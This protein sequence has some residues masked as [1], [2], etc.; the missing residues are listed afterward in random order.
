M[1]ELLELVNIRLVI[2]L[3]IGALIL[4]SLASTASALVD[5]VVANNGAISA[6]DRII[7][8]HKLY[9]DENSVDVDDGLDAIE[10]EQSQKA[11]EIAN[12]NAKLAK[13]KASVDG[14]AK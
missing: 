1:N 11:K 7:L 12:A 5:D 10:Y 3:A 13:L 4:V 9:L 6:Q 8:E 2:I 14:G